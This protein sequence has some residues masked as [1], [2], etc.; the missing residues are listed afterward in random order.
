[1]QITETIEEALADVVDFSS[2]MT[3]LRVPSDRKEEIKDKCDLEV[4][5]NSQSEML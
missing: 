4:L 1:M 3:F 2:G 5:I